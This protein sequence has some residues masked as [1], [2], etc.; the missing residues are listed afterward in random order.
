MLG[1]Q[2][3][4]V[5]EVLVLEATDDAVSP[6]NGGFEGQL[7]GVFGQGFGPGDGINGV[8]MFFRSEASLPGD[9]PPGQEFKRDVLVEVG[10]GG[11]GVRIAT[12]LGDLLPAGDGAD[13]GPQ[14]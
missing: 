12:V 1:G 14:V 9:D 5:D 2:F 4:S 13:E 3:G 11:C 10:K 7:V 6:G 8:L